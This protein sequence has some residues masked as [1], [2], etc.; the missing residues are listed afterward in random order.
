MDG[1]RFDAI[2]RAMATGRSRRGF[3]G[4]LAAGVAVLAG[5]GRAAGQEQ[6][7]CD[8]C[9]I[10]ADCTCSGVTWGCVNGQ[11][12]R[13]TIG[14]FCQTGLIGHECCSPNYV[15]AE[16][17]TFQNAGD[18]IH[19]CQ[20]NTAQGFTQDPTTGACC[21][22]NGTAG[23]ANHPDLCCSGCVCPDGNCCNAEHCQ[24]QCQAAGQTC[25]ANHPC[26][27]PGVLEC[28]AAGT[29]CISTGQQGNAN[30]PDLCCSGCVCEDGNCCDA[31]H[32]QEPVCAEPG[33]ACN[34][35]HACCEG[36][37]CT[38]PDA[39]CTGP[40]DAGVCCLKNG[41]KGN[42]NHP[43]LCCSGCVCS[44]G[45]CC[46]ASHCQQCSGGTVPCG[47]QCIDPTTQCCADEEIGILCQAPGFKTKCCPQGHQCNKHE[48]SKTFDCG[49][50]PKSAKGKGVGKES[51]KR[52]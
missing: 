43:D 52:R 30:H 47:S 1:Q 38:K 33:Q 35:C 16:G 37:R 13:E 4:T 36:S 49:I 44:D 51:K 39:P 34:A 46:D 2:T 32:C 27:H 19:G 7:R 18:G 17:T 50:K 12:C 24:P 22:A 41:S 48:K 21:I 6:P 25:N 8:V 11:C 45:N 29:C 5:A 15:C 20:C 3:L 28:G 9:N 23:N 40:A 42:A 31:S 10:P 26:C 14:I